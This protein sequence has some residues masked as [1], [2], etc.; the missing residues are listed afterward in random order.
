M[1]LYRVHHHTEFKMGMYKAHVCY[2]MQDTGGKHPTPCSDSLLSDTW[3]R[4]TSH[5]DFGM[6]PYLF[7]FATLDQFSSWVYNESWWE[8][9]DEE[10]FV[11]SAV[12]VP[13]G[14]YHLGYTQAV[15]HFQWITLVNTLPVSQWERLRDAMPTRERRYDYYRYSA[16][17]AV[18]PVQFEAPNNRALQVARVSARDVYAPETW[19]GIAR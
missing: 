11:I 9:L 1:L 15:M 2:E 8:Q 14:Q 17:A 19:Y 5:T 6:H 13:Y 7:G 18:N 10:G 3:H 12:E 16:Q 4:I